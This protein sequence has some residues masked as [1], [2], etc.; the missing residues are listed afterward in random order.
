MLANKEFWLYLDTLM[1]SSKIIIDRQK[2]SAHP[3]FPDFIYPVDYGFLQ[4][5]V[6]GDG[7]EIDIFVGT[8]SSR[9]ING[10]LCT[11]DLLKKDAEIKIVYACTD[12]EIDAIYGCMNAQL[13]A[14][15]IPR[16]SI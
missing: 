10:I 5:T 7:N 1:G 12:Q 11:V 2:N 15:F 16:P 4:D 14:L 6:A 8:A 13:R 3:R 9:T